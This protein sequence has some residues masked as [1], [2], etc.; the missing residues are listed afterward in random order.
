MQFN[1]EKVSKLERKIK[2]EIPLDNVKLEVNAKLQKLA[3]KVK[4]PGFRPGKIP[5]NVIKNRYEK[6]VQQEVVTDLMKNSLHDAFKESKVVPV[7]MPKISEFTNNDDGLI[8]SAMFEVRPEIKFTDFSKIKFTK[9]EADISDKDVDDFIMSLRQQ[10]TLWKEA[11]CPAKDGM[12]V[13]V[14]FVGSV[15][16]VEF[17]GG[18][19]DNV[20]FVIGSRSML[21][22]FEKGV[23]G[24]NIDENIKVD[25]QFPKS[26]HAKELASKKAIFSITLKKCY[27]PV[28]PEVDAKFMEKYGHKNGSIEKFKEK[29][30]SN[31]KHQ[32][33]ERQQD[34]FQKEV[35]HKFA[36][37]HDIQLPKGLIEQ[38]ISRMRESYVSQI[39]QHGREVIES[40]LADSNFISQAE[41]QVKLTL[42]VTEFIE[43]NNLTID[44]SKV[45]ER[46]SFIASTYAD[47]DSVSKWFYSDKEQLD[48]IKSQVLESQVIESIA[49]QSD[50]E[51][52]KLSY[53]ELM[54]K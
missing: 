11:S 9:Y 43:R 46:I 10:Q 49:D 47:P 45:S 3:K 19:G 12:K 27:E 53:T 26:Y 20:P 6:E 35:F 14:D 52:K 30:L 25:V 16:G 24:L 17:E 51:I 4:L 28:L 1:I 7:T 5:L 13:E 48:R 44:D 33:Q 39:K 41:Q 50:V 38:E 34:L 21:E 15:D 36:D 18:K 37:A 29:L 31:M 8:F 54:K 2:V 23:I 42:L 40:E 22:D 32:L